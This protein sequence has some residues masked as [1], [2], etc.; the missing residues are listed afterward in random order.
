[1]YKSLFNKRASL[2]FTHFSRKGYALFSCLGKEVIVGTL[3]VATLAHAKA[4]GLSTEWPKASPPITHRKVLSTIDT[5]K[6]TKAPSS[7]LVAWSSS[8]S[9][10]AVNPSAVNPLRHAKVNA[11]ALMLRVKLFLKLSI[12]I[13]MIFSNDI[14]F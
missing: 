14:C 3:S 7:L 12:F 5:L 1:M 6:V 8:L 11:L 13:L 4:E 9:E 10:Q 2:R